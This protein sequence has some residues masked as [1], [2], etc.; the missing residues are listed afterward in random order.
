MGGERKNEHCNELK[1]RKLAQII[2]H[3][4]SPAGSLDI[5]MDIRRP[6]AYT[7]SRPQSTAKKGH[8]E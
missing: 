2:Q 5:E 1:R 8:G 3:C 6:L 4:L 7:L